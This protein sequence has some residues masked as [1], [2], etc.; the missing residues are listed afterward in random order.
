MC[1][2]Y[3]NKVCVFIICAIIFYISGEGWVYIEHYSSVCS[4]A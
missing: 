3:V 1:V 4:G 2:Y